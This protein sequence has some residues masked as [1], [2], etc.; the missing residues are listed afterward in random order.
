MLEHRRIPLCLMESPNWDV[1]LCSHCGQAF[2][3]KRG[4]IPKCIRCGSIGES[5]VKVLDSAENLEDLQEKIA[6]SNVPEGLVSE[7][8][9]IITKRRAKVE[10]KD[11]L[12]SP[13]N[14]LN[15]IREASDHENIMSLQDLQKCL[16]QFRINAKVEQIIEWAEIE[17][18]LLRMSNGSWKL[19]E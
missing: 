4:K 7:L 6:M 5:G 13:R 10:S 8:S 17:G 3:R 2:G 12:N 19:I 11:E 15:A 9:E 14:A 18:V 16:I 1:L